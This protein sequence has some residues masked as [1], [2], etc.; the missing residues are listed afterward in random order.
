MSSCLWILCR[1]IVFYR[2]YYEYNISRLLQHRHVPEINPEHSGC[3]DP[4][5]T[6]SLEPLVTHHRNYRN[7]LCVCIVQFLFTV[8]GFLQTNRK[9]HHISTLTTSNH[10]PWS[11]AD[12]GEGERARS[13]L[14]PSFPK[15]LDPPLVD[16]CY[17]RMPEKGILLTKNCK[18]LSMNL[19]TSV[20]TIYGKNNLLL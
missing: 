3:N 4:Q 5:P 14:A 13:T 7:V 12:L 2:S 1:V 17:T 18:K 19:M 16:H 11:G 10:L 20:F 9:L 15:F 8:L 6:R